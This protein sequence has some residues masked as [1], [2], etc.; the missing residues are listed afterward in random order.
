M[1]RAKILSNK[2]TKCKIVATGVETGSGLICWDDTIISS[3]RNNCI[4][5]SKKSLILHY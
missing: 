1:L 5:V 2:L 4:V 3:D